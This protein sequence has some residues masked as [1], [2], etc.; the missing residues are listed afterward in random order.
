V[1]SRWHDS[2]A[3]ILRLDLRPGSPGR[4]RVSVMQ[5][6][7]SGRDLGEAFDPTVYERTSAGEDPRYGYATQPNHA[8]NVAGDTAWGTNLLFGAPFEFDLRSLTPRRLL[9]HV[10]PS[11]ECPRVSTTA[12]FAWSLDRRRAYFHESLVTDHPDGGVAFVAL[13]LTELEVESGRTRVWEL[14]PPATQPDSR[15]HNFH[16]AFYFERDGVAHVGLLCTGARPPTVGPTES[17]SVGIP[18]CRAAIWIVP[19]D[20]SSQRAQ[21]ELLTGLG[22]LDTSALSHLSV[23]SRTDGFT[24]Y[25]NT[26]N[27]AVGDTTIGENIYGQSESEVAEMYRGMTVQPHGIGQVARIEFTAGRV[28]VRVFEREYCPGTTT[29]GHTWLP[30]NVS[31]D[32]AGE[33]LYCSFAGLRPT[34]VPRR[35]FE[36][37]GRRFDPQTMRYIPA[38]VMRLRAATMEPDDVGGRGHLSYAEPIATAVV[39]SG[40]DGVL[41]TFGPDTGLRIYEAARLDRMIGHA[42]AG[43]LSHCSSTH[44]RPEPAHME[45]VPD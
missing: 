7:P 10:E 44:F 40:E 22:A 45:F 33:Y 2:Q 29:A 8:V 39:G 11:A 41:C 38:L 42:V 36:S 12:H 6:D 4:A 43:E 19:L 24:L 3:D 37:T 1:F 16:S 32:D 18:S 5:V 25:A 26:K 20:G 34:L 13:T 17:P 35:V 14:V 30:I 28:D 27:A 15:T 21:A 23:E 9:R 31:L